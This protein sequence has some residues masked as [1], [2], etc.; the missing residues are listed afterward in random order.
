MVGT[1]QSL[2]KQEYKDDISL[3]DAIGIVLRVM[4]KTMDSTTLGS[5]KRASSSSLIPF[6]FF[7]ALT[8]ATAVEFATLTLDPAVAHKPRAKLFR[9]AEIDALLKKHDLAKK[10]DDAEMKS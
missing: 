1:A 3:E 6:L 9:P 5:E 4:S 8:H 2:L 10:E 7:L